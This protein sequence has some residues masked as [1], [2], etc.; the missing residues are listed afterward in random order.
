MLCTCSR[1]IATLD[2]TPFLSTHTRAQ[3]CFLLRL[4]SVHV[5]V[6]IVVGTTPRSRSA[7]QWQRP[8]KV[9]GVAVNLDM[10]CGRA[11]RWVAFHFRPWGQVCKPTLTLHHTAP[12]YDVIATLHSRPWG[13]FV[14]NIP[15]CT[16]KGN[17]PDY[18][19]CEVL[20]NGTLDVAKRTTELLN[21]HGK[22]PMLAN[23]GY[24]EQPAKVPD[25]GSCCWSLND[26]FFLFLSPSLFSLSFSL[27]SLFSLF[28]F[29]AVRTRMRL[30][31]APTLM[32]SYLTHVHQASGW[33]S[34]GW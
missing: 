15:N 14:T 20:I 23:P 30:T 29:S 33:T 18:S 27:F 26:P 16:G 1:C 4:L 22:I 9:E 28:C 12:Y 7:L 10:C 19:G 13:K 2:G 3:S 34:S 17:P 6:E 11:A 24:F 5:H 8:N 21:K 31:S 32:P 25:G